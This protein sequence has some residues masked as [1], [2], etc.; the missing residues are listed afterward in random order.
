[1]SQAS[2]QD[3]WQVPRWS[4][5]L[6]SN[7]YQAGPFGPIPRTILQLLPPTSLLPSAMQSLMQSGLQSFWLTVAAKAIELMSAMVMTDL[8]FWAW[9]LQNM[10]TT[11]QEKNKIMSFDNFYSFQ[12]LLTILFVFSDVGTRIDFFSFAIWTFYGLTFLST[13]VLRWRR[14]DMERPFKASR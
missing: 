9:I 14:P 11:Y 7:P 3:S 1:M 12:S 8:I 5:P 13:I 6:S 10:K 2:S 4:L